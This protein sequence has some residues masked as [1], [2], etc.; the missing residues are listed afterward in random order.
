M[1]RIERWVS[2]VF[3][4]VKSGVTSVRPEKRF[5]LPV[6][7][8][9]VDKCRM[10]LKVI[11][12]SRPFTVFVIATALFLQPV[13]SRMTVFIGTYFTWQEESCFTGKV[14]EDWLLKL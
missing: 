7:R 11:S 12:S 3:G 1:F 4:S 10:S 8:S 13:L 2:S 5:S 9:E 14:Y 6:Q